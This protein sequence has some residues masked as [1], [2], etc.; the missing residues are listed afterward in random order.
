MLDDADIATGSDQLLALV[1]A[2]QQIE[3][4]RREYAL[5]TD[6]HGL[7]DDPD[8]QARGM[9]IY[10]RIFTPDAAV[11]VTRDDATLLSARGPDGWAE[12]ARNALRDYAATQHLIGTQLV[13]FE[14]VA[15]DPETSA[16]TAGTA[17]MS[18]YL[19]ATHVWPDRRMRLV[20]GTYHDRVRWIADS[21]WQIEDM[22]LAYTS[23]E[24][25]QLGEGG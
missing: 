6:L 4:L 23:E 15:F 21:G 13:T 22:T 17:Q 24:F 2:R 7:I 16:I 10:H 14:R 18:S 5:A 11:R 20:L 19:Q 12:V 8:A 9:R 25:R 1:R 3:Y